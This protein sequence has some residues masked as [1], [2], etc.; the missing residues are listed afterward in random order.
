MTSNG[1]LTGNQFAEIREPG[2]L[3]GP[4]RSAAGKTWAGLLDNVSDRPSAKVV[5]RLGLVV[6]HSAG[7][8]RKDVV[9]FP[10]SDHPSLKKN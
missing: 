5:S 1:R 2:H 7:K 9:R 6:R 4:A 8:R 3:L 10:A